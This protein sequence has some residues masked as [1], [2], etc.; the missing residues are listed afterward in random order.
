MRAGPHRG[1][2]ISVG[3]GF[4]IFFAGA[5]F[6]SNTLLILSYLL[7]TFG[8]LLFYGRKVQVGEEGIILEWGILF[9][10]RKFIGFSEIIEVVDAPSNRYLAFARYAPEV[11][12]LPTIMMVFGILVFFVGEFKWVGLAVILFG[13]VQLVSYGYSEGERR[14]GAALILLLTLLVG[15][16][17]YLSRIGIAFP[18]VAIVILF[19]VMFWEVGPGIM[20]TLFLITE[21]GVYQVQYV[22]KKEVNELLSL[23]GGANEG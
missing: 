12:I 8:I 1:Y 10:R 5:I 21:K 13:G 7:I 11:L 16:I 14:K 18:L 4:A 19:A 17:G 22:S 6:R 3:L 9:K 23:L 20:N 2:W 15:F